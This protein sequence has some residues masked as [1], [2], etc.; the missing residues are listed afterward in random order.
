MPTLTAATPG[1]AQLLGNSSCC[2]LA[3]S[4]CNSLAAL[5][6]HQ[7]PYLSLQLRLALHNTSS[8]QAGEAKKAVKHIMCKGWCSIAV[9]L[10]FAGSP[11][12]LKKVGTS[13]VLV[14]YTPGWHAFCAAAFPFPTPL[15]AGQAS[16]AVMIGKSPEAWLSKVHCNLQSKRQRPSGA[17]ILEK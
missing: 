11:P 4:I 12:E 10:S 16:T 15:E 2:G 1:I 14:G 7:G 8:V 6:H 3:A 9:H 13:D 17:A 5:I